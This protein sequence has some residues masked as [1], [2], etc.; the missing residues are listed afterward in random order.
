MFNFGLLL[1]FEEHFTRVFATEKRNSHILAHLSSSFTAFCTLLSTNG[2]FRPLFHSTPLS[3]YSDL[4]TPL[5][6]L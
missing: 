1:L 3:A 2:M 5:S 4:P 6:I